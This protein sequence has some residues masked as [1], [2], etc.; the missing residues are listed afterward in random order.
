MAA[1][2]KFTFRKIRQT[3]PNG[4]VK[5]VEMIDHPG[6][7][8]IV[9]FLSP[10]RIILLRQFRP[11][12]NKYIYEFPCGTIDPRESPLRCAKRELI[13]ETG[14]AA[15]RVSKL[16]CLYPAPGYTNEIIYVYQADQ[17]TPAEAQQ[18]D[19]EIIETMVVSRRDLHKMLKQ[20][21]LQDSKTVAALVLC[22]WLK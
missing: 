7:V 5:T 2:G 20:G 1:K 6:A 22:G 14:Y 13:E 10:R 4:I 21:D 8:L 17:L 12:L 11:T 3:L 16:G 9:P 18:D 15:T 19:D